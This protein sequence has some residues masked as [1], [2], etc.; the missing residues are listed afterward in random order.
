MDGVVV[1]GGGGGGD[2]DGALLVEVVI[3]LGSW[4]ELGFL[5]Y[6]FRKLKFWIVSSWVLDCDRSF[7]E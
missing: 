5:S 4:M 3:F 2:D 1:V 6:L 7:V